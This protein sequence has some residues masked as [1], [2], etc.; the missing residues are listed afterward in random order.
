MADRNIGN[1]TSPVYCALVMVTVLGL[2]LAAAWMLCKTTGGR[3]RQARTILA[4]IRKTGLDKLIG[5]AGREQW[6][7][8]KS[9]GRTVGWKY[10]SIQSDGQTVTGLTADIQKSPDRQLGQWEAWTLN[11]G[12]DRG[13]YLAGKL[14]GKNKIE[15][16]QNTSINLSGARVQIRQLFDSSWK[17]SG[18]LA[19]DTYIPEGLMELVACRVGQLKA[20][21]VFK[22]V[23]NNIV[24]PDD[25]LHFVSVLM[26]YAG[27]PEGVGGG[28]E[29]RLEF[30]VSDQPS[31]PRVYS[32]APD[33]RLV[34]SMIDDIV[35]EAVDKAK[36]LAVFPEADDIVN[37]IGQTSPRK[38]PPEL[39]Q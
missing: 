20:N 29:V 7:L 14:A 37:A 16:A 1:Q 27:Q 23:I 32:F 9:A 11:N 30:T 25:R 10:F 15:L 17:S 35:E 13:S 6:F 39:P 4:D 36:V 21:A 38:E 33:G 28:W 3:A 34:K 2:S 19:P 18:G 12:A 31:K 8:Q 24:T 22:T 5:P 26:E